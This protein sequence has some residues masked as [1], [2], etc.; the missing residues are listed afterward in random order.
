MPI[1][2][3]VRRFEAMLRDVEGQI[4]SCVAAFVSERDEN[5]RFLMAER[6]PALGSA[7]GPKLVVA[8][9]QG[10]L[11]PSLQYLAAWVAVEVGERGD[12]IA[13][14][15][16]EVEE[17]TVFAVPAANVLAK[18]DI[19]EGLIPITRALEA[20]PVADVDAMSN[21]VTALRDLGGDLPST[22]RDRLLN[23]APEWLSG[24]LLSDFPGNL[25]D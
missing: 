25:G 7:V 5:V 10:T 24:P 13:I 21:Y 15:C 20:T 9:R 17:R 6:L 19:R 4:D 16:R 2:K 11:D 23:D 22:V 12:A 14:L 18:W 8:I 1:E 3:S